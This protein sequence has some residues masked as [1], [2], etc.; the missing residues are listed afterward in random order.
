MEK[1]QDQI[2]QEKKTRLPSRLDKNA[3][4][5]TYNT[6]VQGSSVDIVASMLWKVQQW[7]D[8]NTEGG[9]FVLHVYDD[10]VLLVRDADVEKTVKFL[11]ALMRDA[12]GTERYLGDVPLLVDVKV[13]PTMGSMTKVKPS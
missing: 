7:L 10:I 11:V 9:Q 2:T 8:Q 13:G 12:A 5:S 6:R 3:A 4:R 1:L